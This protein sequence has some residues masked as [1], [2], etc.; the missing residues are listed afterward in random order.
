MSHVD[1]GRY[2][3]FPEALKRRGLWITS[4]RL[5]GVKRNTAVKTCEKPKRYSKSERVDG[6]S[7]HTCTD[8]AFK[9]FT[10]KT[11][12]YGSVGSASTAKNNADAHQACDFTKASGERIN[13]DTTMAR[14]SD[15]PPMECSSNCATNCRYSNLPARVLRKVYGNK[16]DP[17]ISIN[18]VWGEKVNSEFPGPDLKPL[19]I[20]CTC[21]LQICPHAEAHHLSTTFG[22]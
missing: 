10:E 18:C 19:L 13:F 12:T 16:E 17:P 2:T 7:P 5:N 8:L 21:R 15:V 6:E 14:S 3:K 9:K 4:E 11:L 1:H 22:Q 20:A